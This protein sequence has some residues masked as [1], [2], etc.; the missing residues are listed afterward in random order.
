M[1]PKE[2]DKVLSAIEV[3]TFDYKNSIHGEI[4]TEL[5]Q[6][7]YIDVTRTKDG[8]YFDITDKGLSFLNCG[9]YVAAQKEKD[10]ERLKRNI[11]RLSFTIL[12]GI[13]L[14]LMQRILSVL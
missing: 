4:I 2:K 13:I 8:N 11:E 6:A 7:Q 1:T 12:G 9:G 14:Y 5:E 10:K 3:D